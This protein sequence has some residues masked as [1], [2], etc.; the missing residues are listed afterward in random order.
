MGDPNRE[1][2]DVVVIIFAVYN[3][4]ELPLDAAF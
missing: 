4:L 2:W 3:C 1:R